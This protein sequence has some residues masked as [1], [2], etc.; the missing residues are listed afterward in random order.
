MELVGGEGDDA[1]D[2]RRL[3]QTARAMSGLAIAG[4]VIAATGLAIFAVGVHDHRNK[5]RPRSA[6]LAVSPGFGSLWLVGRFCF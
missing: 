3:V 2:A 6:R 4:G 5:A 1:S